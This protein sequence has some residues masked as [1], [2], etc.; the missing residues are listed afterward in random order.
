M[1]HR[2]VMCLGFV[3]L[4]ATIAA[5]REVRTSH[6]TFALNADGVVSIK[7]VN[8]DITIRGWQKKEVD[9]KATKRGPSENLDLVEI[10]IDSTPD[11]LII[12][13]KYPKYHR[14]TDVS[15]EYEL[16]VPH[17]ATLDEV[18]NV[19]GGIDISAV[20]RTLSVKT[21][22]GSADIK[23]TK[24]QLEAETVNGSISVNWA[25]FPKQGRIEVHSVNGRLELHLPAN[26]NANLEVSSLNG[27]IE[28][29]FPITIQGRFLQRKMSGKIGS[30]GPAVELS[31]INGSIDILSTEARK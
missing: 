18:G 23:G 1:L 6:Q 7:N 13:T 31:T 28:S 16:M 8:G 4:T 24:S 25:D 17:T 15:V 9:L 10:K 12:E 11:R 19:N 27:S 3:L 2:I 5:A 22:N 26:A 29:D 30:G 14:D 21:V 20:D